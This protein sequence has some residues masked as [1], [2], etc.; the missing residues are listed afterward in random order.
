M[1][2]RKPSGPVGAG[3]RRKLLSGVVGAIV[4]TNQGPALA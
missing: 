1:P 4:W 3:L 2:V